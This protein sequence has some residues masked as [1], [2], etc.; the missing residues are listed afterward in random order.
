MEKF[1]ETESA[2]G[3]QKYDGT[4]KEERKKRKGRKTNIT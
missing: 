2:A 4:M 3:N 1:R